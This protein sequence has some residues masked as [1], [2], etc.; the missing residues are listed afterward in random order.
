MAHALDR[1]SDG[2]GAMFSARDT[3]WH[4][5]GTLLE[6]APSLR[7]ALRRGG[8]DFVVEIRALFTR[9]QFVLGRPEAAS[10]AR[11]R[12]PA[13]RC[14][15]TGR[16]CWGSSPGATSRYRTATPSACWSPC[17][18]L[19][20]P[21]WRPAARCAAGAQRSADGGA[22][23]GVGEDDSA[24][25]ACGARGTDN[26]STR[27]GRLRIG[28]MARGARPG[29]AAPLRHL[30][31]HPLRGR[32]RSRHPALQRRRAPPA[33]ARGPTVPRPLPGGGRR[34]GGRPQRSMNR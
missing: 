21:R 33:D 2:T 19:V 22:E 20:W 17:S 31:Q 28:V 15:P 12:T 9:V 3:S 13:P 14:G 8:L 11:S 10:T 34:R 29:Q 30:P 27:G 7:E 32:P 18:M 1:L 24:P 25:H 6:R 4:R 5:E 16:R 23:G 26:F